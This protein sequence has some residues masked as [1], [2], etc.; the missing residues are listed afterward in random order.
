MLA[1]R[2]LLA[3][4][5][6][7]F[8]DAIERLL[9]NMV[10]ASPSATG[11]RFCYVNPLLRREPGI[12][13]PAGVAPFRKDT[14][15]ANWFWVACCPTNLVRLLAS[16]SAYT[17]STTADGLY[18][19][20]YAPGEITVDRTRLR[21]ETGYP[22]HG[23]VRVRVEES[24]GEWT[25]RLRVPAWADGAVL[26]H[27]GVRRPVSPGYASVRRVWRAGDEV[28]LELPMGPRFVR[29]D[30]RVNALRGTVAVERG[31]LVYCLETFQGGVDEL[32]VDPAAPPSEEPATGPSDVA[33][34]LRATGR[35]LAY[36]PAGSWPYG[37]AATEG[38]GP[39]DLPLIPYYA[40]G[41]RGPSAMRVW[42]PIN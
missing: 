1:W 18:L 17:A 14:L 37:S 41:N 15:R 40:W 4:G 27:D 8:A 9:F 38:A 10:A 33:V 16:L 13:V 28:L 21:V 29:P 12:D 22:W 31:P 25:L 7:R 34:A 36:P 2:L 42:I 11:D 3:T 39:A 5:E 20:Q 6:V 23:T 35:R 32:A 24:V 19:H 30:P 26:S